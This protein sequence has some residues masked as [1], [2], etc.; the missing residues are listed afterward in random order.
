M[1][2]TPEILF[3][4][5]VNHAFLLRFYYKKSISS[6]EFF[7]NKSIFLLSKVSTIQFVH[8]YAVHQEL[9]INVHHSSNWIKLKADNLDVERLWKILKICLLLHKHLFVFKIR[10]T[11]G[12]HIQMM[13]VSPRDQGKSVL[14]D[15][16]LLSIYLSRCTNI[17]KF[18]KYPKEDSTRS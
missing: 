14:V 17:H 12:S 2:G 6:A 15:N 11:R 9:S 8:F 10:I 13:E 1:S 7:R 5:Q 16:D 18:Q 3:N 4:V